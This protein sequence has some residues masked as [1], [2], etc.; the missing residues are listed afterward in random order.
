MQWQR[1]DSTCLPDRV[2]A[3]PRSGRQ[4]GLARCTHWNAAA[5]ARQ[6]TG[7]IRQIRS[8]YSRMLRSLENVPMPSAFKTALRL[9]SSGCR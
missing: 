6:S 7:L 8:A 9:H 3:F 2:S 1:V 5:G 4:V